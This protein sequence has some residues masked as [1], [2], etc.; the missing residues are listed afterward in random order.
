MFNPCSGTAHTS[1]VKCLLLSKGWCVK[2]D[3][4]APNRDCP[5]D[6]NKRP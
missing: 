5:Q 6:E 4:F 3:C 1:R 2:A